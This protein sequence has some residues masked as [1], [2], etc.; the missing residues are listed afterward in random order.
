MAVEGKR[1]SNKN[2]GGGGENQGEKPNE[3]THKK[4]GKGNIKGTLH[5]KEKIQTVWE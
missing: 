2:R 5:K 3:K 4:G 1:F